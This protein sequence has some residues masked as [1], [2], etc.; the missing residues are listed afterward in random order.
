MPTRPNRRPKSLVPKASKNLNVTRLSPTE[1]QVKWIGKPTSPKSASLPSAKTKIGRLLR[2]CQ[3][4]G[5][6]E[7]IRDWWQRIED[8]E[9]RSARRPPH[10]FDTRQAVKDFRHALLVDID[11]SE[12]AKALLR[13][14]LRPVQPKFN[15][16]EACR[17]HNPANRP[18]VL[19]PEQ[20][21]YVDRYDEQ[22]RERRK[23]DMSNVTEERF[24]KWET[25][26][27]DKLYKKIWA[28]QARAFEEWFDQHPELAQELVERF[29]QLKENSQPE[30]CHWS[31]LYWLAAN[32]VFRRFGFSNQIREAVGTGALDRL[33]VGTAVFDR[34]QGFLKGTDKRQFD[35]LS[36]KKRE[37]LNAAIGQAMYEAH[38]LLAR[39]GADAIQFLERWLVHSAKMILAGERAVD[40]EVRKSQRRKKK[41][42][43]VIRNEEQ[44]P[45]I[46]LPSIRR[47]FD[48][49]QLEHDEN[50]GYSSLQNHPTTIEEV[51]N[52]DIL[53][54][55]EFREFISTLSDQQ[56]A[57]LGPLLINPYLS[58]KA[59]AEHIDL[60]PQ[61]IGQIKQQ[62]QDLWKNR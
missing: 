51:S 31:G 22:E 48:P 59:L 2:H 21:A 52:L 32:V 44:E 56:K 1:F 54:T 50:K 55:V 20:Q 6:N 49:N 45:A 36:E 11:H 5:L 8:K 47:A 27:A 10:I 57:I 33:P 13:E 19:T 46:S 18:P 29:A 16:L 53:S 35:Q 12:S 7:K 3:K 39:K 14:L 17:L 4:Q 24:Q 61:R 38:Q 23:W 37:R 9:A 40:P 26:E 34:L 15:Y 42:S 41:A 60:T 62:I 30:S 58:N 43:Q 25:L 28:D